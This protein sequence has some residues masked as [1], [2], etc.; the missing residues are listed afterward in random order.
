M[1]DGLTGRI[2]LVTGASRGIGRAIAIALA[3]AGADVAVNYLTHDREAGEVADE[4]KSCGRRCLTIKA[5]V[6]RVQD[7]SLM[8]ERVQKEFGPIAVLVNNAGIARPRTLEEITEEDWDEALA[9]NL[10]SAFLVTQAVLPH[11]RAE[12]W[13]R[14]I[15]ISSG[16]AQSGGGVG[17]HYAASKAGIQGLMHFYASHLASEGITANTIA[18]A[19]ITT[20]MT[21]A[22]PGLHPGLVPVGRFGAVEEVAAVAVML[23]HN[24]YITGQTININGG[25]YM[26]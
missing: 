11:M 9:V 15:S 18:P 4:I 16:A 26:T 21:A 3:N 6:S 25:R 1:P 20:D 17:P 7:V 10:K 22:I 5:D 14:I 23:Y 2:A 24:G 13:G 8:V 19:L 12:R